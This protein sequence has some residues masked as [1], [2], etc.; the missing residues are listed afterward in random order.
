MH[1]LREGQFGVAATFTK[2]LQEEKA[3]RYHSAMGNKLAALP[4]DELQQRF[5]EMYN[6]LEHMKAR[7]LGPAIAWARE[8]SEELEARGSTLEFEL[9]KLQYIWLFLGPSVNGLPDDANNG[10]FG[11]MCYAKQNFDRFVD[12]YGA[13]LSALIG[14]LIYSENLADSPYKKVFDIGSK[15]EDVAKLFTREFCSLLG[16]SAESPLLVT[17]NAGTL[18]VPY[19]I[20]YMAATQSKRTEWTQTHEMPFETPLPDSML[21]HSIFV[22]PVSKEQ[23]TDTNPP[24]VIPCG[25]M[26]CRTTLERLAHKNSR[27]K[28]PY[29][30]LEARADDCKEVIL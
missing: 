17:C 14:A 22:C 15:F 9:V 4:S 26:I 20:K 25:H 21:Y 29:C 19:L 13:D 23:T 16:L 2:E 30:P 7:N 8:N 6:I 18:A 5:A 1:L 10:T 24:V 28:C 3:Q 11:A 27:F 12:R